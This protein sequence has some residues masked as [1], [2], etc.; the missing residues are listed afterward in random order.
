MKTCVKIVHEKV[1]EKANE[2]ANE[3]VNEK[4][5]GKVNDKY[6]EGKLIVKLQNMNICLL[7]FHHFSA[8]F[9]PCF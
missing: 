6:L 8:P 7:V 4:V 2:K 9:H 3:K 1:H 5:N